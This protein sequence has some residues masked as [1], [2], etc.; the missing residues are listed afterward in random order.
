VSLDKSSLDS[1]CKRELGKVICSVVSISLPG[2]QLE[3]YES[4]NQDL[5][6]CCR[7]RLLQCI[8]AHNFNDI[9]L[10]RDSRDKFAVNNGNAVV[11]DVAA[12]VGSF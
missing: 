3:A 4:Q 7:T 2:I 10:I 1:V 9:R 8:L 5:A 11:L 12:K 6:T